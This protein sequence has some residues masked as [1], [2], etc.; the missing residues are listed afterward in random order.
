M[1]SYSRIL[2]INCRCTY[3]SQ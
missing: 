3:C 2:E 1:T